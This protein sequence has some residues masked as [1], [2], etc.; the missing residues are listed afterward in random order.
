MQQS[1]ILPQLVCEMSTK[2]YAP[3]SMHLAIPSVSDHGT[4][5]NARIFTCTCFRVSSKYMVASSVPS[6]QFLQ[7]LC[8][9]DSS[10]S[11]LGAQS[12]I[13][14]PMPNNPYPTKPHVCFR[15]ELGLVSPKGH[16]VAS[17]DLSADH[18]MTVDACTSAD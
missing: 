3:N 1:S 15:Q 16:A 5:I 10:S 7:H 18:T 8:P 11:V 12:S 17:A 13:L 4:V 9:A 6:A 2:L 14:W